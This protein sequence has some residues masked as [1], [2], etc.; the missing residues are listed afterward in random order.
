MSETDS[1]EGA[2]E[3]QRLA[4]AYMTTIGRILVAGGALSLLA[5]AARLL[6][7][8]KVSALNVETPLRHVWVAFVLSTIAHLFWAGFL[9]ET[10][11]QINR[12]AEGKAIGRRLFSTARTDH[13]MLR[14]LIPRSRPVGARGRT[15]A[16]SLRDPS[17]WLAQGLALAAFV[18]ILPWKVDH[19]RPALDGSI[20]RVI[21]LVI[22]GVLII[23]A[24]WILGSTWI[25]MLSR[26][27]EA[28]PEEEIFEVSGSWPEWYGGLLTVQMLGTVALLVLLPF[29][30]WLVF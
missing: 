27:P 9:A 30:V 16:M 6:G 21:V 13:I 8:A 7:N 5:I 17:S 26:L 12:L 25:V 20:G 2:E 18:A 28:E 11:A 14:G 22:I 15:Y 10:L 4:N 19:G 3:L 23:A 1:D 29:I 24:N